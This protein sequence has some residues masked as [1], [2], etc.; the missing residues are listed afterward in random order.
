MKISI[1]KKLGIVAFTIFAAFYIAFLLILPNVININK[2]KSDIQQ[3]VQKTANIKID[4]SN[5]KIIT[6]PTL[7][8][9]VKADNLKVNYMDN[10]ELFTGKKASVK[11]SLLP[12]IT[13]TIRISNIDIQSPK[14]RLEVVDNNKLKI[15]EL[16]AS[17]EDENTPPQEL[18]FRISNKLPV[19]KI[20]QSEIYISDT[21]TKNTIKIVCKKLQIDKGELNKKVRIKTIG[22]IYANKDKNISY[23]INLDTFLPPITQEE[24]NNEITTQFINPINSFIKFAPT[25]DILCNLKVREHKDGIHL[26]GL[27]KADNMT[28]TIKGKKLPTS[29]IVMKFKGHKT[30][31]DSLLHPNE[32]EQIKFNAYLNTSSHPK[33]EAIINTDKI[34]LN[35]IKD[36]IEA[37]LDTFSIPNQLNEIN[38]QGYII[39][40]F[41][42]E[43]NLKKLKS[44]GN[45][46]LANGGISHKNY[47][48]KI[49][50]A[51]SNIDFTDNK[52]QIKDTKALI[53]GTML[54]AEGTILSDATT[55]IKISTNQLGIAGLFNAFSPL[56]IKKAYAINKG[57]LT[58]LANIKGALD[59]LKPE[60]QL[61]LTGLSAKDKINNIVLTN[62][63]LKT[64]IRTDKE[65]Y[66]G[67]II[68]QKTYIGIPNFDITIKNPQIKADFDTKDITISPSEIL[69]NSSP[70][71]LSGKIKNYVKTPD[72]QIEAKGKLKATDLGKLLPKEAKGFVLQK[73]A[74]PL[75]IN[76][77]G[78]PDKIDFKAQLIADSNNNFSPITVNK[79]VGKPSIIN[80]FIQLN[81][82]ELNIK[83]IGLYELQ[84]AKN[85]KK[86]NKN[87]LSDSY[88]IAQLTGKITHL[89]K[90]MPR[91][92]NIKL[93]LPAALSV[94]TPAIQNSKLNLKGTLAIDGPINNPKAKGNINISSVTLPDILTKIQNIDLNLDD[95]NIN[96]KI[97]NIDINGSNLNIDANAKLNF[98]N[99]F[100]ISK[101][102]I[103]SSNF[104]LDNVMKASEKLAKITGTQSSQQVG[105]N[106]P[107]KIFNGYGTITRLKSGNA[108][109][110]DISSDFRLNKN[111][112]YL[113]NLNAK[114]YNGN[115]SGKATYNLSNFIT[116]TN[117]KAQ[118]IDANPAVSAFLA[119]NNQLFG[120][121]NFKADVVLK[122]L[123]YQEQIKSLKGN[124][125]FNI[126]NGQMG[127]LG[128]LETFL[129]AN[130]LVSQ[131]F[132]ST[133]LGGIINTIAPY[134]TGNFDYLKGTV[135]LQNGYCIINE[136]K[137]SGD[138]MSLYIDGNYNLLNNYANL[139]IKG[140]LS[141]KVVAALGPIATFSPEKLLSNIPKF[142]PAAVSI[143][144][145]FNTPTTQAQ[146]SQIPPLTTDAHSQEFKVLING[147]IQKPTFVKSFQWLTTPAEIQNTQTSLKD[148]LKIQTNINP[149]P[150]EVVI[151]KTKE[152]AIQQIKQ[153]EKVQEQ[154]Q[155][156][157]QNDK[158]QKIQQFGNLL[159]YYS[160][161]K[162]TTVGN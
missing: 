76:V 35:S 14:L 19:I 25:A 6:T 138:N 160:E 105:M 45:L 99:V 154:L 118:G 114:A 91:I 132:I 98:T 71:S 90:K 142:G 120:T 156:I 7:K 111:V 12:L 17:T 130:N 18:P 133:S 134:N 103:S 158:V 40:N 58:L 89:D 113:D 150:P 44:N 123:T 159:K 128:Q 13:K 109:L 65:A 28:L 77:N 107:V 10:S 26:K 139:I 59:D 110:N 69:F 67:N 144:Q 95:S 36:L 34:E 46:I 50:N 64:N 143:L 23:N 60:L 70:I 20:D 57:S 33:I 145:I 86:S 106:I 122:G 116:K 80:A 148:L 52:I 61:E 92:Q 4:F 121:L 137:S 62:Q 82:N 146:L 162:K 135:H 161:E 1:L 11:I 147:D 74:I 22:N 93:H 79:L 55:D 81:G 56:D 140:R 37:A 51:T 157:Q 153:N 8:V 29:Y 54:K 68:S 131:T 125:D 126:E 96:A 149:N 108:I 104:D 72:I 112:V 43:T 53:N 47:S 32:K 63:L 39:A 16:F 84:T 48:A 87:D 75:L 115:I 119:L 41:N 85:V 94:S 117:I 124:V 151:P 100:T 88:K 49:T 42:L 24:A 78:T 30:D 2:Y 66:K 15:E 97:D 152:E 141:D 101:M 27:F 127:S 155:K 102:T 38:M 83:D 9:G 73:G 5:A 129:K 3:N 136:I 31:I 21:N